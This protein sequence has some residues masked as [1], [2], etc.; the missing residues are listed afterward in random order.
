MILNLGR[1]KEMEEVGDRRKEDEAK[2]EDADL[3][4]PAPHR[5]RNPC[6]LPTHSFK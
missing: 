6:R 5:G 2:D 4:A 1:D 3:R